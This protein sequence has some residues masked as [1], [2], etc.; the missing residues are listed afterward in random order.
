MSQR[1]ATGL[2]IL[3]GKKNLFQLVYYYTRLPDERLSEANCVSILFF[4]KRN[5][6]I[7]NPFTVR[8]KLSKQSAFARR[9]FLTAM[10]GGS[11]LMGVGWRVT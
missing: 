2:Y 1:L 9:L 5:F 7:G 11:G 3:E 8:Q 10:E 6:F 4:R